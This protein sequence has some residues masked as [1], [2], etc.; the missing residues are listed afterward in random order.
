MA[1]AYSAVSNG[2][3]RGRLYEDVPELMKLTGGLAL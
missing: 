3:G 1:E 2:N